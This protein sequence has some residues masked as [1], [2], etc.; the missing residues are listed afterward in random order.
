[1]GLGMHP[2]ISCPRRSQFRPLRVSRLPRRSLGGA[3][4]RRSLPRRASLY[5]TWPVRKDGPY[6]LEPGAQSLKPKAQSPE[7][8]PKAKFLRL[9]FDWQ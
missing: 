8:K 3:G 6:S 9:S 5:C 2:A 4:L 1:M 7:P